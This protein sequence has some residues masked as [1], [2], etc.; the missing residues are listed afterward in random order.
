MIRPLKLQLWLFLLLQ[1][2]E[3]MDVVPC[4]AYWVLLLPLISRYLSE[5]ISE[6]VFFVF[7]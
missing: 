7:R 4:L 2:V 3:G 5:S 1:V 6:M